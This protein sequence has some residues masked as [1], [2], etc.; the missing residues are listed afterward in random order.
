MPKVFVPQLPNRRDSVSGQ[1]VPV[2]DIRPAEEHGEIRIMLPAE[3]PFFATADLISSLRSHLHDYSYEDG[4]SIM[5]IG[6]PVILCAV[7]AILGA[8]GGKFYVLKWD[9]KMKR[10]FK[11]KIFV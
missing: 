4:D 7:A 5:A 11:M 2:A 9:R 10:Y 1:L 8:R 6:D 3:A